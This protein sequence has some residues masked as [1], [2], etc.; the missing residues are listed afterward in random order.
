M[1]GAPRTAGPIRIA[2]YGVIVIVLAWAG[3]VILGPTAQA[4]GACRPDNGARGSA[5]RPVPETLVTTP[6][7]DGRV[8]QFQN[9]VDDSATTSLSSFLWHREQREP[10]GPYGDWERVSSVPLG[11]K[12]Y[13]ATAV[14][15]AD[16]RLEAFLP[17]YGIFCHTVQGPDED[18]AQWSTPVDFGLDPAPYH[19]GVV[20]F[21]ESD[22]SLDAF[23][24]RNGDG[25]S[26]DVR[27][28]R[29]PEEGWGPVRSLGGLPESGVG[30]GQPSTITELPGGRLRL[31]VREWNRDR[32]WE[33]V[34][35]GREGPWN[36]WRL[37][38][39]AECG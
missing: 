39:T 37:C 32:Y 13:L 22:G 16:G 11:P 25:Q 33:T 34:R 38:A 14:E 28:Q 5:D 30:L 1:V 31:I 35:G 23:A 3:T 21:R 10:G 17:S 4:A 24:S 6:R 19:G 7:A 27:V 20:L 18:E 15:N 9:F 36:G 2:L 29:D 8:A 12:N 26:M